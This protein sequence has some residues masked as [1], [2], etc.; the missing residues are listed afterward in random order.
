MKNIFEIILLIIYVALLFLTGVLMITRACLLKKNGF[1][2]TKKY[3][4][5]QYFFVSDVLKKNVFDSVTHKKV[6]WLNRSIL[7]C[8]F[9]SFLL[10]FILFIAELLF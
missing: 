1:D 10:L 9:T 7:I 3:L 5:Q 2:I 6:F 8:F 4:I